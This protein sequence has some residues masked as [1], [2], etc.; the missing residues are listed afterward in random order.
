MLPETMMLLSFVPPNV[1]DK[2]A[3]ENK[4]AHGSHVGLPHIH[5][6]GVVPVFASDDGTPHGDW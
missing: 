4:L 3:H 5:I 2:N 6:L 1:A